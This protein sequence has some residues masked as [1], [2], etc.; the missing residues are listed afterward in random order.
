MTFRRDYTDDTERGQGTLCPAQRRLPN[1]GSLGAELAVT[2]VNLARP[3]VDLLVGLP[4]MVHI[5]SK[6][7][8]C[9][10]VTRGHSLLRRCGEDLLSLDDAFDSL[11]R[12]NTH[13]WAS[14]GIVA[15]R[16]RDLGQDE[17]ANV[18]EGVAHYGHGT[19]TAVAGPASFLITSVKLPIGPATRGVLNVLMPPGG[20][21]FSSTSFVTSSPLK[22]S[23]YTLKVILG[24]ISDIIPLAM[25]L[26]SDPRDRPAARELVKVFSDRMYESREA[27][28]PL[29]RV[30]FAVLLMRKS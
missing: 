27:I 18:V 13:F 22:L 6:G 30:F 7:R 19:I 25:R 11:G 23:A 5:W 1:L 10:P 9:S 17:V 21:I 26:Q 12:A 24:A 15:S 28:S 16:V 29:P 4:G 14:F 3:V 20:R 8:A 2:L